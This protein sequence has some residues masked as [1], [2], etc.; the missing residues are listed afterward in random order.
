MKDKWK[1]NLLLLLTAIIWGLAFVAQRMGGE[2]MGAF[3]F[4][5]IRF[6]LG[7]ISLIPLMV[8]FH[9]KNNKTPL[10]K[11]L[12]LT[13]PSG[14]MA[15]S[16]L[17]IAASLQQVGIMYTTVVNTAFITGLYIILVPLLGLFIK[18][19]VNSITWISSVIAVIG[20]Y[21]LSVQEGFVINSGD[22]I[23]LAGSVFWA[24]HILYIDNI[25]KK[26]DAIKISMIQ[27][28]SCSI[29]SGIVSMFVEKTTF[30]MIYA[31]IIPIFY[32]GIMSVGV[33]YTL[34]VIG[35]KYAKPSHVAIILSL[36]VVFGAIGAAIIIG[37][38]LTLRSYL[39]A[40]LM[41]IGMLLSQLDFK[42]HPPSA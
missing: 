19:K 11:S 31:T 10:M 13:I 20:L 38:I 4:N 3:A 7:G 33:A 14:I 29:L 27:F 16:I 39:G 28:L 17:F 15:G 24:I 12:K 41:L 22:F 8:Y 2:L 40:T 26:Y 34:Q 6:A 42:K 36:E 1:G 5:S 23:Q 25:V 30:E 18:E 21:I 37:E 32:G 9:R 35:Q